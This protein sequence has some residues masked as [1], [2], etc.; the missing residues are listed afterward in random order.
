[1][2]SLTA[3]L[4]HYKR[5]FSSNCHVASMLMLRW[6]GIHLH[7]AHIFQKTQC[8]TPIIEFHGFQQISYVHSGQ[9]VI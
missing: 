1:M 9:A 4:H 8:P 2:W 5:N 3:V 7:A 6:E